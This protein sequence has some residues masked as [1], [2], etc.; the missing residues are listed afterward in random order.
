MAASTRAIGSL[1]VTHVVPGLLVLLAANCLPSRLQLPSTA[2]L[3]VAGVVAYVVSERRDARRLRRVL[4]GRCESCD[5][6][7]TGNVSGVCPECG[8]PCLH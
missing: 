5:Y 2:A 8:V 4:R 3:G 6:D 7:L 1:A